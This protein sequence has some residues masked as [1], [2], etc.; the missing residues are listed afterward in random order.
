MET[1][2][3]DISRGALN[4]GPGIR[5]TVF[6]KGCPLHCEWCH[7]PESQS[8]TPQLCYNSNLCINCGECAKVCP[9][10]AH[11]DGKVDFGKC[12]NCGKCADVCPSQALTMFGKKYSPE[13]VMEIIKRDKPFYDKSNGGITISGGEPLMHRDFCVDLLS[14]CKNE[15]IHTCIETSGMGEKSVLKEYAELTG[16]FLFDWKVS[17]NNDAKK[18]TGAD[19]GIIRE[20]LEFLLDNGYNVILRCPIIPTV[21]DNEKHLYSILDL[22]RK[23]PSLK[24]E[25]L[26]YHNFGVGKGK[27]IGINQTVFPVPTEAQKMKWKEYLKNSN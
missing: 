24:A 13:D 14:L 12:V 10:S 6:L 2:I 9:N 18:Y 15:N 22:L 26:P 16:L 8:F 21:N 25:L 4:D 17:N 20:N 1:Y 27:N 7:N 23:Y 5:T 11:T 3:F 19:T